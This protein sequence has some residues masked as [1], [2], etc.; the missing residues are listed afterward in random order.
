MKRAFCLRTKSC[1]CL[2]LMRS[3]RICK[4]G[5][6][7]SE[8]KA[9][10][11]TRKEENVSTNS[12][13][14]G[15]R[16]EATLLT[17][18][19]LLHQ[20]QLNLLEP[21]KVIHAGAIVRHTGY[22]T[23][24]QIRFPTKIIG[25]EHIVIHDSKANHGAIRETLLQRNRKLKTFIENGIQS[26]LQEE[27]KRGYHWLPHHLQLVYPY[28][29]HICLLL[30]AVQKDATWQQFDNHKWITETIRIKGNYISS[31]QHLH[32]Q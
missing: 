17:F 20:R 21:M 8:T 14:R 29:M 16:G 27:G 2:S 31:M 26:A 30:H 5:L 4:I 1:A 23:Q 24:G 28:L 11:E 22:V 15:G 9:K 7:A 3:S 32:T 25:R 10:K 6:P 13:G 12:A 19:L 18:V